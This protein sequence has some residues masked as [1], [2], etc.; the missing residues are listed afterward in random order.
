MMYMQAQ[1]KTVWK[2]TRNTAKLGSPIPA[3]AFVNKMDRNGANFDRT[4][5]SIKNKV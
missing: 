5:M 2:Q 1:T 4:V 3:V